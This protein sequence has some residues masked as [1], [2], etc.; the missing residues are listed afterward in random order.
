[1]CYMVDQQMNA[2]TCNIKTANSLSPQLQATAT[3]MIDRFEVLLGPYE[4]SLCL[5]HTNFF[6]QY[7]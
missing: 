4:W 3:I 1:M 7:N 6:K 5:K 2:F